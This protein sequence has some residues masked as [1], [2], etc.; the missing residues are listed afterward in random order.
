MT[1][2]WL[3]SPK[4]VLGKAEGKGFS[5]PGKER[6]LYSPSMRQPDY[7]FNMCVT[8]LIVSQSQGIAR[9]AAR[10]GFT[11]GLRMSRELARKNVTHCFA[12]LEECGQ[13]LMPR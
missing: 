8:R 3:E 2:L 1:L 12:T 10:H 13:S 5:C 6:L 7:C 4:D 9:N 11:H